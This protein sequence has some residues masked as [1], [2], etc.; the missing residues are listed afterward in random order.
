MTPRAVDAAAVFDAK[1]ANAASA[2]SA[3]PTLVVVIRAITRIEAEETVNVII[4]GVIP[5]KA[6]ARLVLKAAW[7]KLLTSPDIV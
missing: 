7:L 6:L 1:F 5:L 2:P 3:V 4:S